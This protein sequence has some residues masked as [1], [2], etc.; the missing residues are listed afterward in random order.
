VLLHSIVRGPTN[1]IQKR[2][3]R[4][5]RGEKMSESVAVP[6]GIIPANPERGEISLE[7]LIAGTVGNVLEWYDFGLY[8]Y[9]A[10]VIGTLFFPSHDKIASLLGAYGGFAIGFAMRPL[11]GVLF[12]HLGDRAGR[13]TVL[14]TSVVMMG[15][16][17]VLV[18]VLPTY[19][20]IGFWA[21]LLLLLV[22]MVQGLSVGG[23]FTGSVAYLTETAPAKQRGF[24]GSFANIGSTG[25]YLLA[26]GC[27]TV[28]VLLSGYT[29]LHNTWYWRL[30]F[31]GGGILAILAYL[32]RR[33]LTETGY[34]PEK[35]TEK[36]ELPIK[37]AFRLS[38]RVMVLTMAYTWGYG[39]ADYLALTF[40]PTFASKF[41]HIPESTALEVVTV[42][43]LAV[44]FI[45]PLAGWMSDQIFLRRSILLTIFG[46]LLVSSLGLFSLAQANLAAFILAQIAAGFLLGIVMGVSPATLSEQFP[47]EYRLSG[48]S[49]AFNVGLGI[50]GGTAP[51]IATALIGL[52][53]FN[54]AA[55]A[56]LMVG[57]ALAV[58]ALW[59]LKDHSRQ[60]LR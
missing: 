34:Q 5:I 39:V 7:S 14:I 36:Q 59:L 3:A 20:E 54:L 29:E 56:Y 42:T 47:S 9:L 18:G 48:Y 6:Q 46:I 12:G 40:L 11:G 31:L 49:L 58:S 41:G 37:Q 19:A 43:Q 44:L 4:N 25:G 35:K 1:R 10:P 30:P 50:G 17:T 21:P 38:P 13:Q 51:L 26:A 32:V 52:T 22:R 45:I 23:E 15:T 33:R 60:P 2:L 8:G 27:A 28:T 55:G 16:A 53:G 57:S 24:C